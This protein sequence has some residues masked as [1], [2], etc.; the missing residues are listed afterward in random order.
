MRAC[1]SCGHENA[2][3]VDFCGSCGEYVR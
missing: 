1:P 2:D 3:N